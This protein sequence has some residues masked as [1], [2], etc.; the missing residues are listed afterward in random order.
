MFSR[1]T[2][3]ALSLALGAAGAQAQQFSAWSPA[4]LVPE[5]NSTAA[6]GC[7]IE[8]PDGLHFYL[9]STRGA[10]GAQGGNDIYVAERADKSS[11]WGIPQ[12]IG[13]PVNTS[14][15]D[16][17]PTPLRGGWLLFV[18]ES[19]GSANCGVAA[20]S[21]DIYITRRNRKSGWT[22][23][24]NLGCVANG[25]GPNSPTAEFSPSL[26]ETDAG[27]FLYFSSGAAGTQDIYY[28]K[29]GLDGRFG[30][31][32]KVEELSTPTFDDRMPNVSK[33]G[34]EIVFSSNRAVGPSGL[35]S[36]DVYTSHRKSI[37]DPWSAPER[38]GD[39]VNTYAL[40]GV[41]ANETRAS[42][43]ADRKRMYFGRDGEIYVS[44]RYKLHGDDDDHD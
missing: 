18:S 25:T 20:G 21:G 13:A 37:H 7:P 2:L 3:A 14:A 33:D 12:N 9:A 28:S 41:A 16:Y 31:P 42:M 35:R 38:L 30:A 32:V 40:V 1:S 6:D 23:P 27:T 43:S 24:T 22:T 4:M 8:A 17:C 11:L 36:Q 26:I 5:L 19:A 44:T 34:L 10:P 29:L 39:N 15:N